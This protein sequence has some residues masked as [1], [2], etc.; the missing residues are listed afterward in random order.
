MLGATEESERYPSSDS[1]VMLES[2]KCRDNVTNHAK[3]YWSLKRQP[4]S[5]A[6]T[7]KLAALTPKILDG[8]SFKFINWMGLIQ[9]VNLLI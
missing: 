8:A 6:C 5:V 1:D 7:C 3:F 9:S 2:L 4:G